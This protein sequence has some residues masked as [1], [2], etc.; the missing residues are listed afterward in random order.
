MKK[1]LLIFT[2][3]F[4]TVMFSSPSFAKWMKVGESV[5]INTFYVDFE[6]IRKHDGY[7]YYW[8]LV[9]LLKPQS[10]DLSIKYYRQVDC[11][12][13]RFKTLSFPFTNNRWVMELVR[14]CHLLESKK[15]GNILL[16]IV[17]MKRPWIKSVVIELDRKNCTHLFNQIWRYKQQI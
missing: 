3:L 10:G 14:S 5:D 16:Q 17:W 11:Q 6:R 8:M 13:F 1:L 2:L 7:V 9:N 12:L 15:I 4:S